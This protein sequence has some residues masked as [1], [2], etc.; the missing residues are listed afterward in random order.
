MWKTWTGRGMPRFQSR[1]RQV[2]DVIK[3]KGLGSSI[4]CMVVSKGLWTRLGFH[5]IAK[6]ASSEL[7]LF[8]LS[9]SNGV[10]R[11]EATYTLWLSSNSYISHHGLG[12]AGRRVLLNNSDCRASRPGRTCR[13]LDLM[14]RRPEQVRDRAEI[15]FACEDAGVVLDIWCSR[16]HSLIRSMSST[17]TV[18]SL[19][20]SLARDRSWQ[21]H[22]DTWITV[23][24]DST[25]RLCVD[26]LP[27]LRGV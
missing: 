24:S 23:T 4:R 6:L 22:R 18:S 17:D 9:T 20:M 16:L 8:S 3:I 2:I 15:S 1:A 19:W 10:V 5:N 25:R 7:A 12:A 27:F 21:L 14:D 13:V 11:H 26:R